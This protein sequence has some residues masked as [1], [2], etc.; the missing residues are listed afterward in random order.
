MEK[1]PCYDMLAEFGKEVRR[2]WGKRF[3]GAEPVKKIVAA[4]ATTGDCEFTLLSDGFQLG[5]KH[6]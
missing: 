3:A 2:M 5:K 6:R 1:A 4:V